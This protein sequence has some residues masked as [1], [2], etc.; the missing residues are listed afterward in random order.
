M[1]KMFTCMSMAA[2]PVARMAAAVSL[3]T[4]PLYRMMDIFCRSVTSCSAL[5]SL[6]KASVMELPSRVWY[7][8]AN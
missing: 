2:P 7:N 8:A 5:V 6:A 3:S 1:R 4:V